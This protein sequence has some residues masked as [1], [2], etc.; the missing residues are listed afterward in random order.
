VKLG[1]A[2][3]LVLSLLVAAGFVVALEVAAGF[4]LRA[5]AS[6]G[7]RTS[8]IREEQHCEYDP[9][10]GWMN[11]PSL[12]IEDL[13]GPGTTYNTN[14]QRLRATRDYAPEVPAGRYRVVCLGDSFTMGYGVDDADTFPARLEALADDLEVVNMGLGGFGVDQDYLWFRRDGERLDCDALLFCVVIADFHRMTNAIFQERYP[15]PTLALED[16]ELVVRNVPVPRGFDGELELEGRRSN[17]ARLLFGSGTGSSDDP[18]P[19]AP[20]A[21]RVFEELN[22][23]CA[24]RGRRFAVVLL[25]SERHVHA[26]DLPVEQW[27]EEFTARA[28]VPFLNLFPVMRR[29]DEEVL[30]SYFTLGHYAPSGN[31][32]VAEA[33]LELIETEW[34][35]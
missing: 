6:A 28:G 18:L 16:G 30:P 25:P 34:R 19:F 14:S 1:A 5:R 8:A 4:A 11:L 33:L 32:L 35:N 13:Y 24:E 17:L 27:L 12:R 15:K 20:V 31:Q 26:G 3:G 23:E 22:R 7:P 21:E 9:D 29:I 2:K 10:L